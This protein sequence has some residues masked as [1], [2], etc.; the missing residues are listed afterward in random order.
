MEELTE[1][2]DTERFCS[3]VARHV[4]SSCL[5]CNWTAKPPSGSGPMVQSVPRQ[6]LFTNV[7]CFV[8][9]CVTTSSNS[10]SGRSTG[11]R[12]TAAAALNDA[13]PERELHLPRAL[14]HCGAQRRGRAG[15]PNRR[16]A[17]A[18]QQPGRPPE[19]R[20]RRSGGPGLPESPGRCRRRLLH[21]A[22]EQPAPPPRSL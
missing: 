3:L 18:A 12:Q 6:P 10:S 19:E 9:L 15:D 16:S 5:R 21:E 2:S 8:C 7:E 22:P 1:F 20:R 11:I 14:C 13:V 4:L 17:T